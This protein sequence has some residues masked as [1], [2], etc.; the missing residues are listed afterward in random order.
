MVLSQLKMGA[1]QAKNAN[2]INTDSNKTAWSSDRQTL[3]MI[4]NQF[5]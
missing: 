2:L 5:P 4:I 1:R 3:H